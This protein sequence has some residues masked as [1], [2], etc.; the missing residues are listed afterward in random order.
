MFLSRSLHRF[1]PRSARRL[2]AHR[3]Q[4]SEAQTDTDEAAADNEPSDVPLPLL[5]R[6]PLAW[7]IALIRLRESMVRTQ[8][9]DN[10]TLFL[11]SVKPLIYAF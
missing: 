1:A 10:M 6:S 11:D 9:H 7:L 4:Q 5:P 3:R 2:L 8:L